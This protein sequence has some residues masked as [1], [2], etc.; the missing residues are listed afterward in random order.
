MTTTDPRSA[1]TSRGTPGGRTPPA[2]AGASRPWPA[3]AAASSACLLPTAGAAP[4]RQRRPRRR[5]PSKARRRGA[6]A[7][8]R[9]HHLCM[10][11]SVHTRGQKKKGARQ[12]QRTRCSTGTSRCCTAG[13]SSLT[14][15]HRARMLCS[16]TGGIGN[17]RGWVEVEPI[18][19]GRGP[20]GGTAL[21]TRAAASQTGQLARDRCCLSPLARSARNAGTAYFIS[22]TITI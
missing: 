1:R 8:W 16:R 12:K 7:P 21:A 15:G 19:P 20:G 22:D 13:R 14:F 10:H 18:P 5:R 4:G 17:T 2:G 9:S 6:A 3:P 11:G